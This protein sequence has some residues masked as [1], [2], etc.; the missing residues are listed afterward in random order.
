MLAGIALLLAM[1]GML[2]TATPAQAA[3]AQIQA[4]PC[5]AVAYTPY[6]SGGR[7]YFYGAVYCDVYAQRIEI[8]VVRVK[9]GYAVGSE[10][11]GCGIAYSGHSDYWCEGTTSQPDQGGNQEWCT[12]NQSWVWTVDGRSGAVTSDKSCEPWGSP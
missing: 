6:L 12:Y 7:V 5:S 11:F 8:T 3:P 10:T 4:V 1:A 9:N 2:T